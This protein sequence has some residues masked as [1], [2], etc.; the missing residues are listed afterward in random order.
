M[1]WQ[2]ETPILEPGREETLSWAAYKAEHSDWDFSE[3]DPDRRDFEA[4][5][6]VTWKVVGPYFC[7][8][9]RTIFTE[10]GEQSTLSAQRHY[11]LILDSSRSMEGESWRS[12]MK[13]VGTL[14]SFCRFSVVLFASF[15]EV[16]VRD[17]EGEE[18]L[19]SRLQVL[20]DS[21][22]Q[23]GRGSTNFAAAFQCAADFVS[24][25]E[26]SV[27]P[28]VIFMSDGGNNEGE[29]H[30]NRALTDF[31]AAFGDDKW[32]FYSISF[33]WHADKGLIEWL[34][35]NLKSGRCAQN[36]KYIESMDETGLIDVGV[37]VYVCSCNVDEAS[38]SKT[39]V[40]TSQVATNLK[41]FIEIA[42]PGSVLP[43]AAK[44]R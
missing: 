44:Q 9:Y 32:D 35:Q 41:A 13:A 31:G 27:Q 29:G 34:A 37:L 20:W 21:G 22:S 6:Q 24:D 39:S 38:G 42:Q 30:L 11:L 19:S 2:D 36:S 14:P 40:S 8:K 25:S 4:K 18:F 43:P 33:G 15:A 5:A 17:C 1:L 3:S 16:E 23:L 28:V 12:L 10:H 26:F 7:K